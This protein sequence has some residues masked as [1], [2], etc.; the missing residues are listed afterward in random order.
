[1][2]TKTKI[3]VLTTVTIFTLLAAQCR[4][5]QPGSAVRQAGGQQEKATEV[6]LEERH[7]GEA[8]ADEPEADEH[9]HEGEALE[10]EA[11]M[12]EPAPVDLADGEKLKVIATTSIVADVVKKIGGDKIDLTILLP[13][14]ADPHTFNPAP[15]D[16]AAV[17]DAHVVFANGMGLEEFL[18]EM[19]SNAGGGAVVVH[20]SHGVEP[21]QLGPVPTAD[22]K[23]HELEEGHHHQGV[24]P[25]TWTSPAN[26]KIFVHNIEHTLSALDPAHSQIFEANARAYQTQL[27][28][29]DT[30]VKAQINS[31]PAENR[32]LVTDH[33]AF[34]YYAEHYGLKQVGAVIPSFSSA[35]EPSAKELAELEDV[36][37]TYKVKAIFVGA[38]VN[39][40][41]AERVANDTGVKLVTLYTGSLGAAG[42]EV[43]TYLDYV[44]YNTTAI[45]EALK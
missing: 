33:T 32:E 39:P 1:M 34:G 9:E 14:G 15:A 42:S 10:H 36:I 40:S 2:F 45:V 5:A 11:E 37:K 25:H 21:R 18:D 23:E 8:H 26:V 19:I 28:E 7:E 41:L 43:E 4:A 30:W 17:A 13:I 31:I 35:A 22:P 12:P 3:F 38:S 20:V 24:D 16:L 44:R 6:Y 29:L 27:D